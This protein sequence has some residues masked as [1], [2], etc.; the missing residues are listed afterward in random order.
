MGQGEAGK[1][2]AEQREGAADAEHVQEQGREDRS[3]GEPGQRHELQR[4]EHLA[5][6]AGPGQPGHHGEG[7]DVD[8]RIPDP[9][10]DQSQVGEGRGRRDGKKSQGQSPQQHA[11]DEAAA[12]PGDA[13]RPRGHRTAGQAAR[14]EGGGEPA[15]RGPAQ[16]QDVDGEHGDQHDERAAEQGLGERQDRDTA[17]RGHPHELGQAAGDVADHVTGARG[18]G[19]PAY[20]GR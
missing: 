15:D 1:S 10:D 2:A 7:G 5:R 9:D 19:V 13:D 14:A 12:Q 16:S 20:R 17:G 18:R 4:A 3:G 8:D 11:G 6:R